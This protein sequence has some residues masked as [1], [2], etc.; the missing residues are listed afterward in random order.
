M[1]TVM[2]DGELFVKA[3]ENDARFREAMEKLTLSI[4]AQ[5]KLLA[6]ITEFVETYNHRTEAKTE[7]PAVE[8]KTETPKV[9]VKDE[10]IKKVKKSHRNP[11]RDLVSKD[12]VAWRKDL[13][14][15]LGKYDRSKVIHAACDKLYRVYGVSWK[16]EKS[17]FLRENDRFPVDG[18]LELAW[19]VEQRD[20][21]HNLFVNTVCD[22]AEDW[23]KPELT[24]SYPAESMNDVRGIVAEIAKRSGCN[25]SANGSHLYNHIFAAFKKETQF[26]ADQAEADYK[27]MY[28]NKKVRTIDVIEYAVKKQFLEWF[29]QYVA[30]EYHIAA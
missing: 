29:N 18:N 8:V 6:A 10:H 1:N 20:G 14:N 26:P 17:K 19:K 23:K 2:I 11:D 15:M 24:Y 3:N 16:E 5:N 22:V 30:R 25:P 7:V 28:P 27:R 21:W 9:E 4:D 13:Y 12:Y